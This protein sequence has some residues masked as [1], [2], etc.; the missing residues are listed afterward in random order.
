MI[1]IGI[2][3]GME[4]YG[5]WLHAIIPFVS[6]LLFLKV[7]ASLNLLFSL[8]SYEIEFRLDTPYTA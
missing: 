4:L 3:L 1:R 2:C 5:H 6:A 7:F 8:D